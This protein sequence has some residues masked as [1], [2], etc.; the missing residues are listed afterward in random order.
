MVESN[1][2]VPGM[3]IPITMCHGLSPQGDID[4]LAL[5]ARHFDVAYA[6][7]L[8]PTNGKRSVRDGR[9]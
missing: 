5:T 6:Q 8:A 1:D 2:K 3:R 9:E 4:D 7:L